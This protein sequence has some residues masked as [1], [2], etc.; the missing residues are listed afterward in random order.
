MHVV[1][2]EDMKNANAAH[3][4]RESHSIKWENA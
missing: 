2:N 4:V 3:S 1:K